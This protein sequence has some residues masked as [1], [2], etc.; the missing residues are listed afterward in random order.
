MSVIK[1]SDYIVEVLAAQGIDYVFGYQGGNITHVIDSIGKHPGVTFIPGNHEQGSAFSACAYAMH[2]ANLGVALSSSGPGAVNLISG[3][4]NAYYDSTPVLFLTGNVN[5]LTMRRDTSVRQNAFQE[6]DIISMVQGITKYA[7][8]IMDP[9]EVCYHV[10]KAI[11]LAMYGRR[12]PVLLDIPHDVQRAIIEPESALHFVPQEEDYDRL[13]DSAHG[14]FRSLIQGAKRPLILAGG[15]AAEGKNRRSVNRFAEHY[16]IPVVTS[17]RGLDVVSHESDLFCGVIGS[18]GNRFA[19]LAMEYCDLLLVFGSRL[20]ERQVQYDALE[21]VKTKKIIR[22]DIDRIELD[23]KVTATLAFHA[24]LCNVLDRV[25]LSGCGPWEKWLTVIHG[26]RIRF[27]SA[28]ADWSANG[29]IARISKCSKAKTDYTA[30]VGNNQMCT[31]QSV[32]LR[33]GER[34]LNS[35]GHGSMGF[36]IPAAVGASMASNRGRV[37]AFT[38]DGGLRMN[39]QELEVIQR[40]KLPITVVVINNS[41]LGM[42]QDVQDSLF[43]S[44][45]FGTDKSLNAMDLGKLA[46]AFDMQYAVVASGSDLE[47][48]LELV[49]NAVPAILEVRVPVR[50]VPMAGRNAFAQQP[51]L[52][53]KE[54]EIIEL[55]VRQLD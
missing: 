41:A 24:P 40:E 45:Y 4:A 33:V 17:L 39:L 34:L 22:I 14:K 16:R 7:V 38:G 54:R 25:D 5:R 15:G 42:I 32:Y 11:W 28:E 20:D 47:D 29:V 23:R 52:T 8:Q 6:N 35:A 30:D 12:G 49:K 55:E 18:Y 31:A 2:T 51:E 37:I 3:V 1:V 10:E 27:P 9:N 43:E 48:C 21:I 13:T 46:Q 53:E 26:W 19:N 50:P 36:S 44:R